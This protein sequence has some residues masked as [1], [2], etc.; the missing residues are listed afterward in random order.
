MRK[1]TKILIAPLCLSVMYGLYYFGIPAVIN[2][3]LDNPQLQTLIKE[4]SGFKIAFKNPSVKMGVLPAVIFDAKNI[5]VLNDDDSAPLNIE[6]PHLK[7]KLLPLIFKKIEISSLNADKFDIKLYLDKDFKLKLGQYNLEFENK[8]IAFELS[9]ANINIEKYNL[10]LKDFIEN[11]EIFIKSTGNTLVSYNADKYLNVK[12]D[13][14]LY[15]NKKPSVIDIDTT[16]KLPL[17]KIDTDKINIKG[18]IQ[19][20]NLA[21]FSSYA[22]YFSK[23]QITKLSGII[24]FEAFTN[25]NNIEKQ[26]L[27][28]LT[29]K[30]L[31]IYQQDSTKSVYCKDKLT[32][33]SDVSP[34]NNA[35]EINDIKVFAK[36]INLQ[37][38]G[39]IDKIN[40]SSPNLNITTTINN[41]R[42]EAFIPL[43]PGIDIPPDLN[44]YVLKQNPFYGNI[45]GHLQI[46]G[47]HLTPDINGNILVSNGYLIKPIPNTKGATIKLAFKKKT[48]NLD[49]FVPTGNNQSVSVKGPIDIYPPKTAD[50]KI[51][52]SSNVD[53]ATAQFVLNPLHDILEFVIGPVPIMDIKGQ[54]GIDLRVFGTK[55]KP[56]A[57]GKFQFHNGT[58]SFNDI[59][60]MVIKNA[61]GDLIFNDTDTTFTTKTALLNGKPVTVN[62]TCNLEGKLNFKVNA[63]NQDLGDFV[64]IL[65]TSPMTGDFS[66]IVTP[67]NYAKGPASL[68]LNLTGQIIDPRDAQIGKNIFAKG[69]VIL[70]GNTISLTNSPAKLKNITGKI[71]FDNMDAVLKL[72]SSINKSTINVEGKI[73][74]LTADLKFKSA[75]FLAEDGL[76]LLPENLKIPFKNDIKKVKTSFSGHYKGNLENIN[77]NSVYLKGKIYSNNVNPSGLLIGNSSYELNNGNFI[78]TP[79]KGKIK[80]N[81]YYIS[82]N[83][84]N[85]F[86]KK[87]NINGELK[88]KDFDLSTAEEFAELLPEDMRGIFTDCQNAKGTINI[89]SK[90]TNNQ[91]RAYAVLDGVE[92]DYI[93]QNLHLAIIS[94]NTFLNGNQINLNKLNTKI[95]GMPVFLNGKISNVFKDPN[96]DIYINAK[97]SQDFI[98]RFFNN[99]QVYPL[100]LKGDINLTSKLRGTA[101]HIFTNSNLYIAENSSIYYMGAS[102]GDTQNPV[103]ITTEADIYGNHLN[104]KRLQYDKIISSQNNKPFVTPQLNA[105]GGITYLN[106][107]DIAFKNFRIKTL[108][109]TDAKI[110]NI[111]FRKPIMKQGVFTSDIELNGTSSRPALQGSLNISSIDMPFYNSSINDIDMDIKPDKI[112]VKSRGRILSNNVNLDA[113]LKNK[114]TPPYEIENVNLKFSTLNIDEITD[115]LR[116]YEI[117]SVQS[118]SLSFQTNDTLVPDFSM[119]TIK[120]ANVKADK[121][122]VKS[123]DAE[124]FTSTI[125][126]NDKM[127]FDVKDYNFDIA[128]GKVNGSASYN[129]LTDNVGIKM[130]MENASAQM[131]SEALFDLKGQIFGL[132]T[133]DA[134]LKCNAKTNSKCMQT[135]SGDTYFIVQDGKMPK[136]GS[137]EYL[138]KAGNLITSGFTS[139]SIN[140]IIDLI[141]PLKTGEFASISGDMHI[142][143]GI[144]QKINIYSD[145]KDLNMYMTGSYNLSTAIA[146][147]KIFGSLSNNVTNVFSKIKNVSLNTLFNTIP[148]VGSSDETFSF[149]NEIAKIP[150]NKNK[151]SIYKIFLVDIYGDI[152]GSNYVKSFKW[153]K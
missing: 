103:T 92:F 122:K 85:I 9:R 152:N 33:T 87:Q 12:A 102:I 57:F 21:D 107:N 72:K 130:H 76:S 23:G 67:I 111:V 89:T 27:S 56:H 123:I 32:V 7:V 142:S 68:N 4:Q 97:P 24:N 119:A 50:L 75:S 73:N 100:K 29:I 63:E 22:K 127:I 101:K 13:A 96:L 47:N 140:G 53:L 98:D 17:N 25:H 45:V 81:P 84:K 11:K 139:L 41:S 28:T 19:N 129:L 153:I 49:V 148:W 114:L 35:L 120:Q 94:G 66:K 137:L 147:M 113:T 151:S 145:G 54:G 134:N 133:G 126:L 78:L 46:S 71:D 124:N 132:V 36:D 3:K 48:M 117:Q 69:N 39:K 5:Q 43:M 15:A 18:K 8:D 30:D 135:L 65:G 125:S 77:L 93:P 16:L 143:D 104:L 116:D 90:I 106:N 149:Q 20:L 6:N 146:D 109:P 40:T 128:Q 121:I 10:S 83:A 131:M 51:T 82:L 64:K 58:V 110:F 136:L 1:Y 150:T 44:L 80:Q 61:S 138:L 37:F 14:I 59:N 52:S 38:N 34:V 26:I 108:A 105:A 91:M 115:I 141:T 79:L 118:P 88:L 2:S 60:N 70:A 144:A 74:N 95:G 42:T 62:G 31:G 55:A 99:K 86:S 112:Y